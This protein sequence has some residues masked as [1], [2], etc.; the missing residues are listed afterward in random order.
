MGYQTLLSV[1]GAVDDDMDE[2][3]LQE[4]IE[5][6][7]D[8]TNSG[9]SRATQQFTRKLDDLE[10]DIASIK[11]ALYELADNANTAPPAATLTTPSKQSHGWGS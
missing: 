5:A 7:I 4:D 10:H 11:H 2:G 1:P 8:G 3:K 9:V 6:F